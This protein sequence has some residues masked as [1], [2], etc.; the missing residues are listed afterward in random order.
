MKAVSVLYFLTVASAMTIQPRQFG[1]R[2]RGRF[3]GGGNF[4]NGVDNVDNNVPQNDNNNGNVNVPQNGN[5]NGNGND[6]DTANGD[7][8]GDATGDVPQNNDGNNNAGNNNNNNAG[9]DGGAADDTTNGGDA[10]DDTTG[11]DGAA[12]DNTNGGGNQAADGQTVVFT[13]IGGVP[14]NECLTFRN[15]GEIVDAACVN[16]AADRQLTPSANSLVVQRTFTAGFRPDLVDVQACVGFNGTHFRAEDC[17]ADGI[18]LVTF[19][20]GELR[21]SGGACASGHDDLAQ[22]TVDTAG[23]TCATYTTTNVQ[24]AAV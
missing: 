9:A 2:F 7:A 23:N 19:S 22:M 18:E 10:A 20:N 12:G 8:N 4:G 11:N 13:E 17:N 5:G 1:G 21:A 14:G 3:G 15:N 24:P 6:D 16:E